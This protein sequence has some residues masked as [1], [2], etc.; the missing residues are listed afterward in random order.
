MDAVVFGGV[1]LTLLTA[2]EMETASLAKETT[3]G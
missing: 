2:E 1:C 3:L